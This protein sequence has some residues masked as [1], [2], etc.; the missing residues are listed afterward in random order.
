MGGSENPWALLPQEGAQGNSKFFPPGPCLVVLRTVG[1]FIQ[2]LARTSLPKMFYGRIGARALSGPGRPPPRMVGPHPPLRGS[3]RLPTT[4]TQGLS[5]DGGRERK[6][7]D[8]PPEGG[9]PGKF[10]I[11]PTRPMPSCTPYRWYFHTT[12]TWASLPKNVFMGGFVLAHLVGR[13]GPRHEWRGPTPHCRPGAH[14]EVKPSHAGG[15]QP[16][17]MTA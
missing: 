9:V 3:Q 5:G 11:F 10:Q 13:A 17:T 7:L 4:H 15:W 12:V 16:Q 8:H 2:L 14:G 6:S 1:T